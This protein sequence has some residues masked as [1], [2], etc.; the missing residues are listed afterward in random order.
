MKVYSSSGS[1]FMNNNYGYDLNSNITQIDNGASGAALYHLGGTETKLFS[2]DE[3]NRLQHSEGI[4]H[5][6]LEVQQFTLDMEYNSLHNIVSK[7][8]SHQSAPLG[9]NNFTDTANSM[10]NNYSYTGGNHPHAPSTIDVFDPST[11]NQTEQINNT[12]DANGNLKQISHD[13][14]NTLA[15]TSARNMYWDEQN[16][17]QAI[18]EN[19]VAYHYVYDASG[20]RVLKSSGS[21]ANLVVNGEQVTALTNP[22]NYT[23]YPSGYLVVG[24]QDYTK[25]YY[26]GSQRIASRMGDL[27][28]IENFQSFASGQGTAGSSEALKQQGELETKKQFLQKQLTDIYAK[29]KLGKPNFTI[30]QATIDPAE[31]ACQAEY[32]ALAQYWLPLSNIDSTYK[33][34]LSLLFTTYQQ[35]QSYCQ[36]MSIIKKISKCPLNIDPKKLPIWWYHPDHL[37]SSSYLTDFSGAPSHYYNYLPFGEEMVSQNNSSYNNVYRFSGKELDQETGLSYFG[38]RYYDP[39]Y[40]FWLS[41]DPLAEKFPN[42]S[43]YNYCLGNPVNMI[44]PDGRAATPPDEYLIGKNGITRVEKPGEDVI[45][46]LDKKGNRTDITQNIGNDTQLLNYG[47]TQVLEIADQGLAKEAFKKISDNQKNEYGRIDYTDNVSGD[48]KSALV[49]NNNKS[50][51]NV[52]AFAKGLYDLEGGSTTVN[53]IDHNHPGNSQPSGFDYNYGS[54]KNGG[55]V[56]SDPPVGDAQVAKQYPTNNQGQPVIHR[57]YTPNDGKATRYDENKFYPKEDY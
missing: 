44:D 49:T 30:A 53:Q 41:V 29:A 7:V 2:Y 50:E 12:Y 27:S 5:G 39:K 54:W 24:T 46:I 15:T 40:S 16:R 4:W 6:E 9:T 22:G 1:N 57:V 32:N 36:T 38:A 48:K 43:P 31:A 10:I 3:F 8:Q 51:V 47:S 34:C 11:G 28:T 52:S 25:H 17:L 37:G 14:L 55:T 42:A 21:S 56:N 19:G 18:A 13:D 20:E 23:M 26:A 45:V 35:T 33:N